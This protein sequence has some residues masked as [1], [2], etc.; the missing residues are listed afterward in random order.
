MSA[1]GVSQ[2]HVLIDY[3]SLDLPCYGAF[4]IV[5]AI[6][7]LLLPLSAVF[8]QASFTGIA[9]IADVAFRNNYAGR[10]C[11]FLQ[12]VDFVG[13]VTGRHLVCRPLVS[14]LVFLVGVVQNVSG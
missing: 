2:D 4:E 13:L 7:I 1:V 10:G 12:C 5:D 8:L 3:H 11:D 9:K 14:L 6:T